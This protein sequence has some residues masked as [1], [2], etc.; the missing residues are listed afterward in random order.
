MIRVCNARPGL[1][2]DWQQKTLESL[3]VLLLPPGESE[4]T[5]GRWI[6]RSQNTLV[7]IAP[8]RPYGIPRRRQFVKH[9]YLCRG[10][11][12]PER[13]F[14]DLFCSRFDYSVEP[15]HSKEKEK[16]KRNIHMHWYQKFFVIVCKSMWSNMNNYKNQA[17]IQ[18][19]ACHPNQ[20]MVRLFCDLFEHATI[21]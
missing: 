6:A 8:M 5:V 3:W 21:K 13:W 18:S 11:S 12:R 10:R 16:G 9:L 14:H 4:T 7:Y 17:H 15:L 1:R 19:F 20:K 2:N